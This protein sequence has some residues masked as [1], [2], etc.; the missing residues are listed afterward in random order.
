MMQAKAWLLDIGLAYMAAVGVREVM[1]LL[2]VPVTYAIPCTPPYCNRVVSWQGRL[3]PVM[4]IPLRVGG[5]SL[6]ARFMAVVGFRAPQGGAVDYGAIPLVSPPRQ[7][8]VG[9]DQACALP[10]YMHRMD[11]LAMSCFKFEEQPVPILNLQLLFGPPPVA[12]G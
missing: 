9:D 2:D 3:L 6:Q 10:E 7:I 11:R 12:N 4:D 5:E 8:L 1:H